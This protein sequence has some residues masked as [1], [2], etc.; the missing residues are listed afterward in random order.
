MLSGWLQYPL[1]VYAFDVP[2]LAPDPQGLRTAT[3]GFARD[4]ESWQQGTTGW[5]WVGPWLTRLPQQWEPWWLLGALVAAIALFALHAT[6]T[7]TGARLRALMAVMA[8]FGL[9]VAIWWAISPPALRF[10]WGP[11][12]GVTAILLGWAL[13]RARWQTPAIVAAAAGIAAVAMVASVVRLDWT[14]PR[15]S[16]SWLGIPYEVVPLPRPSTTEFIT[17]SEL[18]LRMPVDTDQC[19]SVYPLCTP[20]PLP[21]L[22]QLGPGIDSGFVS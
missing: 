8:P 15:E 13:W 4:P 21:S 12:F 18:V 22:T 20:D 17:D 5:D 19:W 16:E 2:W 11:L 7:A 9:A 3:L 10:G 1:S 6:T 14:S